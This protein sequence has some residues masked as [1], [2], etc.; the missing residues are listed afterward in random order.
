M[1]YVKSVL[2]ILLTFSFLIIGCSNPTG[3]EEV[4]ITGRVFYTDSENYVV[5]AK[6]FLR[7]NFEHGMP[8]TFLYDSTYTNNQGYFQFK[9]L[10]DGFYELYACK[11]SD[12]GNLSHI[13]PLSDGIYFTSEEGPYIIEDIFLHPVSEESRIIGNLIISETQ[14]PADSAKVLLSRLD[15]GEYSVI[16][17]VISDSAGNFQFENIR[18]GTHS[19]CASKT[20]TLIVGYPVYG[21]KS[22]FCNGKDTYTDTLFLTSMAVEKPA[23]YIYPETDRQFQVQLIC[24]NGTKITKSIPEYNEGWDVF[25]EKS[26][27]IDGKYDYLFY[28]TA[29]SI[30]LELFLGWCISQKNLKTELN[31]LLLNIGLNTEETNE[32]L[33]YWLNR[34]KDYEYYKIFPVVNQQLDELVELKMTPQP[35]TI[36]RILFFFQGCDKFEKL[37]PPQIENFKREGTTVIEWGGVLLN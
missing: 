14:L 3:N 32:F 26:G 28:E 8:Y 4:S 35:K 33:D 12:F 21:S 34:L 10:E 7:K 1:K 17:S 13:S 27:R 29:I 25:V 30:A 11:Y 31:D 18:T 6:V 36:F 5:R 24:K 15:D 20:D 2:V 9:G 23:I 19:I 16:D 22:F 37:P